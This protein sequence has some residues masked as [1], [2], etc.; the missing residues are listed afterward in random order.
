MC[1]STKNTY[2]YNTDMNW[3]IL[4]VSEKDTYRY[5]RSYA[6]D[7]V[8][9]ISDIDCAYDICTLLYP[10]VC[11]CITLS[12]ALYPV[13]MCL[14]VRYIQPAYVQIYTDMH[15]QGAFISACIWLYFCTEYMHI[16]T[17]ASSA[18]LHVSVCIL[19]LNTCRYA[20]LLLNTY[21]YA[22]LHSV[23]ICM[24]LSVFWSWIQAHMPVHSWIKLLYFIAPD[25][26]PAGTENQSGG[27]LDTAYGR[28]GKREERAVSCAGLNLSLEESSRLK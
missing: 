18:Y 24:Y 12:Y 4:Y 20:F 16:C 15:F 10:L 13:H 3:Y 1:I 2:R 5:A 21:T 14:Y 22:L 17:H 11:A 28:A 9:C 6:H 19:I 23:H 27:A 8:K 25:R 7:T 26:P